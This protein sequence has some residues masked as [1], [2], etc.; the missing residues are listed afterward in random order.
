[1]LIT[2]NTFFDYFTTVS[3]INLYFLRNSNNYRPVACR[4]N[5]RKFSIKY[6]GPS[7]WNSLPPHLKQ[8]TS[9]LLFKNRLKQYLLTNVMVIWRLQYPNG[10][11][12][13]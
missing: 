8:R 2:T 7:A 1:M 3:S 5:Y 4:T 11:F 12:F 13:I 10:L 6:T 9:I